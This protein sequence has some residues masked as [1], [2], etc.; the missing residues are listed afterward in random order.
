MTRR[1]L[2][3]LR[4]MRDE[5]ED[6][7]YE[8]GLGY[9]GEERISGRTLFALLRKVAISAEIDSEPGGFER[10]TINETGRDIL[11]AFAKKEFR[12]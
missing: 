12:K 3:V 2:E 6:L 1:Q 10:Y 11:R 5:E 8:R 4:I 7:V 9:V